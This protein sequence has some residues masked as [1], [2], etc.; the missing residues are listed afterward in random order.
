MDKFNVFDFKFDDEELEEEFNKFFYANNL[1]SLFT[2]EHRSTPISV[3]WVDARSVVRDKGTY[4]K[5]LVE[6]SNILVMA[7]DNKMYDDSVFKVIYNARSFQ[8]LIQIMRDIIEFI[9]TV[10]EEHL[11]NFW[12]IVFYTQPL[13]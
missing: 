4:A 10:D 11:F 2:L 12:N 1:T 5:T 8:K 9:R 6:F 7:Q 3:T 13:T